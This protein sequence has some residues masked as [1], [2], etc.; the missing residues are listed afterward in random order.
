MSATYDIAI[1]GA[2]GLVGETLIRILEE[3]DFP[4]GKLYPLA[5]PPPTNF[6]MP[7]SKYTAPWWWGVTDQTAPSA[8]AW[9]LDDKQ[10]HAAL[11][12]QE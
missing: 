9:I 6:H 4:V 1:V 12:A 10:W 2:T 11:D 5:S 8:P 7:N 3:R